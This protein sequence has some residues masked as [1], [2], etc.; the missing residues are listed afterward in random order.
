MGLPTF[1]VKRPVT[2]AMLFIGI[3]IIGLICMVGIPVEL[4]PNFS[5]GVISIFINIRGGMPPSEV[6][7]LVS[8][9]IEESVGTATYLKNLISISEEGQSIIQ[10]WFAPGTNMDLAR[11][12]VSERFSRVAS[13]L[14]KEIEK[15]V[16]A[17]YDQAQ[18]PVFIFAIAGEGY[19][20]E[21]LRKIVDERVKDRIRRVKGVGN[22]EVGG[23]RER[24]ILVEIDQAKL[25]S[26]NIPILQVINTVNLNNLNLLVGDIKEPREKYL[27]RTMGEFSTLEQLGNLGIGV[28]PSGNLIRLKDVA[29]I[30]DSFLEAVSYA[31]VNVLPVV[32]LY[33]QKESAGNTIDI[34]DGIQKELELLKKDLDPKIRFIPT[35][36]QAE[37]IR[38]AIKTVLNSL[39]LG[40]FLA[41]AILFLFLR[42]VKSVFIIAIAIPI[43]VI[44]TFIYMY[45]G[46]ITRNVMTL[47]GLAVGIG[48]LVDNSIVVLENI[49]TKR[50]KG[51]GV[52]EAATLGTEE[53][54]LAITA[55]TLTTIE[56]FLPIIYVSEEIRILY[57]GFA[58]TVAFSLMASLFVAVTLVPMLASRSGGGFLRPQDYAKKE[59]ATGEFLTK[60][61]KNYKR[62]LCWTIRSR[63]QVV[64]I[65]GVLFLIAVYVLMF[66]I[67]KEFIGVAEQEDFTIFIE[68]PTGYKLEVSNKIV[69][70][71]EK[72]LKEVREVKTMTSRVEP[73]SS[74]VYVSLVPISQRRRSTRQVIDSLRPKVE[75]IQPAFIYFEEPQEVEV[76]EVIMDI[77]GYDYDVLVRLA[78]EMSGRMGTI[79]GLTDVKIRFR[80]GR[81]EYLVTPD[82]EKAAMFGLTME[83]VANILHA[84]MRGLRA[85]LYHTEGKE[86]EVI[87]RLDKKDRKNLQDLRRMTIILPDGSKVFL[88]QIAD[89]KPGAGAS[90]IW[91]KNKNR[92]IQVS[93]NKGRYAFG[94]AVKLIRQAVRDVKFPEDYF[95]RFGENYE[96]MLENQRQ[97][98]FALILAIFLIYITIAAM[99]ESYGQPLIIMMS[100][101]MAII[102]VVVALRVTKTSVNVGVLIGAMMLFGIV[103]NNG[104]ILIDH[105]NR[106]RGQGLSKLRAI[107]RSGQDR[108][109]PIMMTTS[110]TVLGL[111]PMAMDRSPESVFWSPLAITV[112]SGLIFS[113]ILTLLILPSIYIIFEDAK[114][115]LRDWWNKGPTA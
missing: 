95:Y 59:A 35:Y 20:P 23:G 6:E 22:V 47:S 70:E 49:F 94:T 78:N 96:K 10:M 115:F 2:I 1:S 112:L 90:K 48:M 101:P 24:K 89:I 25:Q 107:I 62:I 4:Y 55:S 30:K 72:I 85:T 14:P 102:G 9:P 63:R 71:V 56:V 79:P 19:T 93:A 29:Q 109:R 99:F 21:G 77:Y 5:Y 36:N 11:L 17:K 50:T 81:P 113:T 114:D 82:K 12:D 40:G 37:S 111:L 52:V 32:N 65:V 88:E 64:L 39:W 42:E 100:V 74:K 104:I 57:S 26:Y 58:W 34:V 87:V 3:I 43:S 108:M 18:R 53:M 91:R 105:V 15:P 106:L 46:G 31:R 28:T 7:N 68:L 75:K 61:K 38:R 84:Q 44:C 66:G 60:L 86:I 110:T 33:V 41:M 69:A 16:I 54:F 92:M 98:T 13:K 51:F 45:F 67:E 73:W 83:D 97:L 27:L 80:P 76:N 8:K 103:V